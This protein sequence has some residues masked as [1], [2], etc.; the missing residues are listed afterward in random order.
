M[1]ILLTLIASAGLVSCVGGIDPVITDDGNDNGDNPAGGDLTKAKQ[2]Y[3][4]NVFPIVRKCDGGACHGET[5]VG[6][7]LTRFVAADPANAWT[8][9]VGYTALVGTFAPSTAPILTMITP[10]T[11][12]AISYT[13]DEEAKIV[14][15]LTEE[16]S[17]R[18]GAPTGE[19]PVPGQETLSQAA[20]RVMQGFAGC[21]TKTNFDAANMAN[22]WG[23]LRAQNNSACQTC[24]TNGG[25]GFI[26]SQ[27]SQ[28]FYDVVSTKKNYWLQYFT[29]KL[30]EG[31]AAAKV[32]VNE[33]SFKGVALSVAPH[34]EHPR[35]NPT[36]NN[37]MTALKNL[38]DT[39]MTAVA[40]G[41][42]APGALK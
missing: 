1:R 24:H 17:A 3:T 34:L 33:V 39:T 28:L 9:A 38:Y 42:C 16:V 41:G 25:H 2:L 10:G 27:Q 29:V 26:A 18:N 36:D 7:T 4:D 32:I 23:N 6:A 19:P 14:E 13:A 8:V 35:F 30:D 22:A 37:G 31:P 11:H 21:M 20:E 40:A 5:A 12:K 15:W